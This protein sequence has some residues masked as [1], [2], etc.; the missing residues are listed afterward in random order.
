VNLA[1]DR[2]DREGGERATATGV[3]PIHGLDQPE[4]AD[5][6]QIVELLGSAREAASKG[7][8]EREVSLD[9][10][11]T[12]I[13]IAILAPGLKKALAFRRRVRSLQRPHGSKITYLTRSWR[14][15]FC[16]R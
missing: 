16:T 5:L 2:R 7:S 9:Q 4:R 11:S 15:I 8:H 12:G 1:E 10:S 13:E 14:Q 3:V 6:G